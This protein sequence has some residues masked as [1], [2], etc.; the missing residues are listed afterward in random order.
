MLIW[1]PLKLKVWVAI[2]IV[3]KTEFLNGPRPA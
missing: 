3:G 2:A 1:L